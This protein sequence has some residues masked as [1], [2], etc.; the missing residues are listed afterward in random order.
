[1][2]EPRGERAQDEHP[3]GDDGDGRGL[4]RIAGGIT[5]D[6][7]ELRFAAIRA[8]GPGGQAVNKVSSAVQL[9]FDAARSPSLPEAVR[10]RLLR[11]AGRRASAE[12]VI[13][14]T[15]QRHRSQE[16][17]RA[18]AL[19][20]LVALVAEA[21]VPPTPRRATRPTAASKARRLDAKLRRGALKAARARPGPED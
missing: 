17:N 11:L 5:L 8:S 12:G 18:D 7:G 21:A 3:R 10:A 2:A 15:A 16:R 19:A 9:R 14:I 13:V 6:P 1:M 20:R 4:L